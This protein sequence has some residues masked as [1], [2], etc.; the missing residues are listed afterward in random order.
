MITMLYEKTLSRKVVSPPTP[1]EENSS[2]IAGESVKSIKQHSDTSDTYWNGLSRFLRSPFGILKTGSRQ[3]EEVS[4]KEPASM[5]KI[6]NLMR[7]VH[8]FFHYS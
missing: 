5:G 2:P 1:K 6:L 3:T 4:R 7:Y 8:V